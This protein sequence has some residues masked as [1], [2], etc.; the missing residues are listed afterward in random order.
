MKCKHTWSLE[1]KDD[2]V[3]RLLCDSTEIKSDAFLLNVE[4]NTCNNDI[5]RC[6]NEFDNMIM[7]EVF[8]PLF[9]QKLKA[10]NSSNGHNS[11]FYL[12]KWYTSLS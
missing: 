7:D 2:Y 1:K 3:E 10:V 9:K 12:N 8:F 6:M 11:I 5:N 4:N